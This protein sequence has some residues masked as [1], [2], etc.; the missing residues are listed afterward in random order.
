MISI[1]GRKFNMLTALD[2][3]GESK[4]R[5]KCDC[6]NIK[7][8]SG[9]DVSHGRVRSCGC[10]G[11]EQCRNINL[12]KPGEAAF[13]AICLSYKHSAMKR[14][15]EFNLSDEFIKN[16]IKLPCRYCGIAPGMKKELPSKNGY[17]IYNGIDR[18]DN[19][20]GYVESNAVPCCRRC[21]TRKGDQ[22]IDDFKKWVTSVYK[23]ICLL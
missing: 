13:R 10:L 3:M 16:I 23:N 8:L 22:H 21:N 7:I 9:Y 15:L 2:Y 5:C 17:I 12:K 1:K 14:N 4:W 20:I 11:I 18:L 6:G 19:D